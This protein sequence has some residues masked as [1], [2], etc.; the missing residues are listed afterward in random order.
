MLRRVPTSA[1]GQDRTPAQ[2][3]LLAAF[4]EAGKSLIWRIVSAIEEYHQSKPFPFLRDSP[5]LLK[6]LADRNIAVFSTDIDTFDFKG[7][8]YA[9]RSVIASGLGCREPFLSPWGLL[10][11][12]Q[13]PDGRRAEEGGAGV[14]G[15]APGLEHVRLGSDAE[16]PRM[17]AARPLYPAQRTNAKAS[18][19]VCD[20]P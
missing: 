9:S 11:L 16:D 3:T 14:D 10:L 15:A 2:L 8:K 20:G 17:S 4:R 1:E 13:G 7:P 5:E 18:P 12:Q 19:N 6:Y